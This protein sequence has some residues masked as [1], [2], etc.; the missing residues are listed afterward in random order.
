MIVD[1][2]QIQFSAEALKDA[3]KTYR[4]LFPQK[5]PPGLLGTVMIRGINPISLGVK[6]QAMG[7]RVYREVEMAESEVAAML[8]LYCRKLRIP[9]PRTA[10]KAIK[11]Q[12]DNI[13]LIVSKTL[14]LPAVPA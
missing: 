10:D 3:V 12:G 4:E 5:Q 1:S 6:V 9:L 11:V 13:A 7:S 8:I 2:R 14:T